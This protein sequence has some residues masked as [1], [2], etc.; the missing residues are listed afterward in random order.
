MLAT[1][2]RRARLWIWIEALTQFIL[3]AVGLFWTTL[4]L[5]RLIEPPPWLRA[6][7]LATAALGLAALLATSLLRR[8]TVPLSDEA[9]A[10]AVERT[11]PQFGDSLLTSI[12]LAAGLADDADPDLALRTTA[13]ALAR[14]GEVRPRSLFRWRRLSLLATAAVL[15]AAGVGALA[16]L[17]PALTT[18]WV[19]RMVFLLPDPWPRQVMLEAEGFSDGVRTVARG[20]DVEL[21][22]RARAAGP[23]P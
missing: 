15:A 12:T 5:D 23:L 19:R 13:A 20:S 6:A 16:V 8:L 4:L 1:V 7:A 9:L 22:V 21:I 3:A 14:L 11:H 10:L 2:R 17:R 18:I